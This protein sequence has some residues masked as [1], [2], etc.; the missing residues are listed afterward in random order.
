MQRPLRIL[1]LDPP[2]QGS[3]KVVQLA[4][5]AIEHCAFGIQQCLG[6]QQLFRILRL[7]KGKEVRSMAFV[8]GLGVSG[9]HQVLAGVLPHG[10]HA[11]NM[12]VAP[13]RAGGRRAGYH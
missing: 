3:P 6:P 12:G 9:R 1:R 11:D 8:R 13:P 4:P 5:K 10:F 7:D 2:A